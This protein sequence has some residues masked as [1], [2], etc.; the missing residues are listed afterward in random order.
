M[1]PPPVPGD[2]IAPPLDHQEH[3][4][5]KHYERGGQKHPFHHQR[6]ANGM[7]HTTAPARNPSRA[8]SLRFTG[9]AG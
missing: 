9:R 8:A 2:F 3:P 1:G 4:G 7:A 6:T 5:Q